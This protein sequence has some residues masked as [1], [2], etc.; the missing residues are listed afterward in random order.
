MIIRR[1]IREDEILDILKACHDKPCGGHFANKM[2]HIKYFILD[3][4]GQVFLEMPRSM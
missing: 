4:I 1:Y 2:N 3:N